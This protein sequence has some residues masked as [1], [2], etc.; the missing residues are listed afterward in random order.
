MDLRSDLSTTGPYHPDGSYNY[1]RSNNLKIIVL[2]K[3]SSK[4][5][6]F[7]KRAR[8]YQHMEKVIYKNYEDM[9]LVAPAM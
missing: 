1:R 6:D 5:V 7:D 9:A 8:I 4:K 3:A 2:I